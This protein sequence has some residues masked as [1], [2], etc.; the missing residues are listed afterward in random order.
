MFVP[1]DVPAS[2]PPV[3]DLEG[4]CEAIAR[5]GGLSKRER[6]ILLFMARGYSPAYIA[7]KLFL[8]DSTVRTHIKSVY[9]KLGVHSREE[10]LQMVERPQ[11]TEAPASPAR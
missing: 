10:L 9:R 2:L 11:N 5:S 6:E 8:S 1:H 7:K 3:H 4:N